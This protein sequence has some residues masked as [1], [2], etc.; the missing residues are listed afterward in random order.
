[1][2]TYLPMPTVDQLLQVFKD[3]G[4]KPTPVRGCWRD[5]VNNGCCCALP[6][7]VAL[8]DP[9]WFEKWANFKEV[10]SGP[11]YDIYERADELYGPDARYI[12]SGFDDNGCN[13]GEWYQLGLSL[14]KA[15]GVTKEDHVY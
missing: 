12:Y 5:Y 1:M 10:D 7:L 4:W 6:A 2:K 8:G 9:E 14:R 15:L 11:G 3:R 13:S